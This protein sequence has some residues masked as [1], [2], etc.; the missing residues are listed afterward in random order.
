MRQLQTNIP[1]IDV[2]KLD[3]QGKH[4]IGEA[5]DLGWRAG[6]RPSIVRVVD[7]K[8]PTFSQIVR[9]VGSE[10]SFGELVAFVYQSPGNAKHYVNLT[11]WN[12]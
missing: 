3:R 1:S 5:S 4:F 11:I 10:E 12:D 6:C 7:A 9:Y 8:D 2:S